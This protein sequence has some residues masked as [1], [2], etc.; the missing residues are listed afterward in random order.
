MACVLTCL[1]ILYDKYVNKI[2]EPI[3]SHFTPSPATLPT[4]SNRNI[5]PKIV[6]S[7]INNAVEN[8]G[9]PSETKLSLQ[10]STAAERL[11]TP[12]STAQQSLQSAIQ[13]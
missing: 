9:D 7:I 2:P 1:T 10:V 8:K 12:N 5:S 3:D 4:P 13:L 11:E 6:G